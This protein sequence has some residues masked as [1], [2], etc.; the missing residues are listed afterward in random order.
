M[1]SVRASASHGA[2][3]GVDVIA[4]GVLALGLIVFAV[5]SITRSPVLGLRIDR[6][7]LWLGAGLVANFIADV[8]YLVLDSAREY[9]AGTPLDVLWLIA[10]AATAIAARTPSASTS[11]T[12]AAAPPRQG[13]RVLAVPAVA[14]MASLLVLAVGWGDR[15]P[16]AAGFC[17]VGCAVLAAIRVMITFHELRDLPEARRQARTDDL[18]GLAN[19][20]ALY[21]RCDQLL[22]G[23]TGPV[24]CA[25]LL[26]ELDGFKEINDSLGH[27]VGDQVLTLVSRGLEQVLLPDHLLARLGGDEFAILLPGA[28]SPPAQSLAVAVNASLNARSSSTP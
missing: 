17:A 23:A 12:S 20:R 25:L 28:S 4:W 10:V 14:A 11:R 2:R 3:A 18:T 7:M 19:R 5:A 26:L 24:P 15:L 1:T 6:V 9:V 27:H 21:D 13:W 8:A 16:L 22:Q